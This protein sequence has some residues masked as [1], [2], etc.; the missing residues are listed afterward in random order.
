MLTLLESEE[1]V[2]AV[3]EFYHSVML[4]QLSKFLDPS[5][6]PWNDWVETLDAN[7]GI[8]EFQLAEVRTAWKL[9]KERL[10]NTKKAAS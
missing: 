10:E 3:D 4:P 5:K 8:P 1:I 2:A 6:S 9:W 7:T